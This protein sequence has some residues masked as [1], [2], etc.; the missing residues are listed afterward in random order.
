MTYFE[1]II[2]GILATAIYSLLFAFT[3]DWIAKTDYNISPFLIAGFFGI[4]I[5]VILVSLKVLLVVI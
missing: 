3:L 4:V 1:L 2:V 5:S